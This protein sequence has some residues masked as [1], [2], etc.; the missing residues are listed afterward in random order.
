MKK[1]SLTRLAIL[2]G[3]VAGLL[4]IRYHLF[5]EPKTRQ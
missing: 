1:S 3:L 5:I 4:S 2:V